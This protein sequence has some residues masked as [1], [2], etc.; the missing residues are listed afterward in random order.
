MQLATGMQKVHGSLEIEKL[1]SLLD[2]DVALAS[3]SAGEWESS[4]KWD[5][6]SVA[7][8]VEED[9]RTLVLWL[10]EE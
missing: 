3:L 10:V 4:V 2:W 7:L 1:G 9:F 8:M 6:L 5:E